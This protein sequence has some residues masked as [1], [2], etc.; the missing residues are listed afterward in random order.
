MS[1][2]SRG[3]RG[4]ARRTSVRAGHGGRSRHGRGAGARGCR[5]CLRELPGRRPP[6]PSSPRTRRAANVA[7]RGSSGSRVAGSG[8]R[9][10]RPARGAAAW[11][12]PA[13]GPSFLTSARGCTRSP[14]LLACS[15]PQMSQTGEAEGSGGRGCGPGGRHAQATSLVQPLQVSLSRGNRRYRAPQR[16]P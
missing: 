9:F 12:N 6:G 13:A 14:H 2:G 16:D 8:S 7:G 4:H 3:S 15:E 10:S 1:R 11:H 5:L